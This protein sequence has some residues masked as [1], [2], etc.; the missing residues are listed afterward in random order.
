MFDKIKKDSDSLLKK[1]YDVNS[2]YLKAMS[3]KIMIIIMFDVSQ[4]A[5]I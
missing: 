1:L 3:M 5:K 4:G 2:S